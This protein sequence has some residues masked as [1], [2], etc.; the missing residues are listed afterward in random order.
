MKSFFKRI[1][2]HK[3]KCSGIRKVT[4]TV[5]YMYYKCSYCNEESGLDYWQLNRMTE[6][7]AICSKSKTKP[8]M[9]ESIIGSYD[10]C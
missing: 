4:D 3:F 7:M 6:S 9:F 1:R 2:K 8:S 10:C 5:S